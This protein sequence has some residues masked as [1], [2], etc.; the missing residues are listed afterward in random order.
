MKQKRLDKNLEHFPMKYKS[1]ILNMLKKLI[2]NYEEIFIFV[3][4]KI[5]YF[6]K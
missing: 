1:N 2:L 5:F 3:L 6:F 4:N